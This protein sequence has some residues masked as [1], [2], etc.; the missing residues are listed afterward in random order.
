MVL[1]VGEGAM[2]KTPELVVRDREWPIWASMYI[3]C[4][5]GRTATPGFAMGL[6]RTGMAP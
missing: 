6:R 1:V 2:G 4:D 3:C 5:E